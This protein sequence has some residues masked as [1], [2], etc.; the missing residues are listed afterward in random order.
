MGAG[1]VSADVFEAL[2]GGPGR[3]FH[4]QHA[5]RKLG[6]LRCSSRGVCEQANAFIGSVPFYA[7]SVINSR[8]HFSHTI[9]QIRWESA[10]VFT[11]GHPPH[12][13]PAWD[14]GGPNRLRL[15]DMHSG[16]PLQSR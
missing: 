6:V 7:I 16:T 2:I 12:S 9:L 4:L 5:N 1:N 15:L 13:P 11:Y 10:T 8:S 14:T 3:A